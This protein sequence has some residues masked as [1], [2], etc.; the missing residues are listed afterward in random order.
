MGRPTNLGTVLGMT[1]LFV[2]LPL[3]L[4]FLV[5]QAWPAATALSLAAIHIGLMGLGAW[6]F[7]EWFRN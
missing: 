6:A 2:A 1:G 7:A 4:T 3:L 5:A